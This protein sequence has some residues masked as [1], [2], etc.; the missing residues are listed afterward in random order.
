MESNELKYGG[1]DVRSETGWE[2]HVDGL[3]A[4]A[5]VAMNHA[6]EVIV[7]EKRKRA[8]NEGNK[9]YDLRHLKKRE[10]EGQKSTSLNVDKNKEKK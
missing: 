8:E 6:H 4:F 3:S 1:D 10:T 9:K 5:K 7:E 2:D